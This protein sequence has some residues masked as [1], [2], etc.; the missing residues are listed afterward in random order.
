MSP[1]IS[2]RSLRVL[3]AEDNSVNQLVLKMLL[4]QVGVQPE[5]VADGQ[6][7]WDAWAR[8]PWDLILM[9]V[10][11]PVMDG[12]TAA[13]AIR[14]AEAKSGRTRTPI[15]ALI[16]NGMA[17]QVTAYAEAGMDAH[18]AKPIEA[19]ALFEALRIVDRPA[20]R[21]PAERGSATG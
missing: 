21:A 16:A 6:A 3:V 14:A 19:A 10:Q 5:I 9:D 1:E 2:S 7:A 13:R 15:V 12:P 4:G 17:H 18:V 20:E 11:M 8:E